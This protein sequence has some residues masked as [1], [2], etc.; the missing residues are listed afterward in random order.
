MTH[1]SSLAQDL[2]HLSSPPGALIRLSDAHVTGSSIMPNKRNPDFAEVTRARAQAVHALVANL[3]GVGRGALC[4]YNR[5]T[6]WTKYW[7]M[8][9][10]YEVGEA[11]ELFAEVI[12]GISVDRPALEQAASA[13]FSLAADLADHLAVS[14]GISFRRAYHVVAECVGEDE[15][16]GWVRPETINAILTREKIAPLF[17]ADE[18]ANLGDPAHALQLRKSQGGPSAPDVIAQSKSLT[19]SAR[20]AKRWIATHQ[21]KLK[22]A[23]TRAAE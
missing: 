3:L 2:I 21:T 9:L 5:D 10:I 8:D 20:A 1:L 16:Y 18:L 15:P 6:Q 22:T 12:T 11:P 7:I 17:G 19:Q 13:G 14:R 4:G 23:R